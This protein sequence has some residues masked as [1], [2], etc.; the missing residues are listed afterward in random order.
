MNSKV[1]PF[2]VASIIV[3]TGCKTTKVIVDQEPVSRPTSLKKEIQELSSAIRSSISSK[4][5]II[6]K[7]KEILNSI[8]EQNTD[9]TL[10]ARPGG[11]PEGNPCPKK[12]VIVNDRDADIE[13]PDFVSWEEKYIL[14][15]ITGVPLTLKRDLVDNR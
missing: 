10:V 8:E 4:K 5:E 12:K 15:N 14:K 6:K 11:C 7:R 9:M 13:P 1:C 3:F 2:L